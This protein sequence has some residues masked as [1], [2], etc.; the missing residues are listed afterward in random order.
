MTDHEYPDD[1]PAADDPGVGTV[2]GNP[3]ATPLPP[4][5]WPPTIRLGSAIEEMSRGIS[6]QISRQVFGDLKIGSLVAER[7]TEGFGFTEGFADALRIDLGMQA[8]AAQFRELSG[9]ILG[10][11]DFSAFKRLRE[12]YY[13]PNWGALDA[14][15]VAMLVED[16]C[17]PLVW[18]PDVTVVTALLAA[19]ERAAAVLLDDGPAVIAFGTELLAEIDHEELVHVVEPLREVADLLDGGHIRGAQA[20]AAVVLCDLLQGVLGKRTFPKAKEEFSADWRNRPIGLLRFALVGVAVTVALDHF[21]WHDGDPMP[22]RF[23]RHATAHYVR[24]EQYTPLNALVAYMTAVA[25]AR[26]L[27]ELLA[28]EDAAAT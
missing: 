6:E 28:S 22:T 3:L 9:Q 24:D 20:L 16:T 12:R 8:W 7:F 21:H 23:N 17:L 2:D 19:P 14:E 10:T 15:A 27:Q 18:L 5:R 4:A 1:G 11:I 25:L 26:E 13:P